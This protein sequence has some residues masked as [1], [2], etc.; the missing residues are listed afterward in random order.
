MATAFKQP[1]QEQIRTELRESAWRHACSD[2][3]KNTTVDTL[4]AEAGISKGAFYHFYES[5]ELLFLDVLSRWHERIFRSVEELLLR[6]QSLSPS[7]RARVA[8]REGLK[9]LLYRPAARFVL[10]ERKALLRR[11][12]PEAARQLYHSDDELLERM[13]DLC[14]VRLTISREQ[15]I[16]VIRILLTSLMNADDVGPSFDESLS[17]LIDCA[18]A[19]LIAD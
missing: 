14:G 19:Q 10:A 9:Q 2:G 12:P 18:C 15:A 16:G 13:M 8:F 11:V 17:I 5:K 4:A 7:Q 1:E 6:D 3:M